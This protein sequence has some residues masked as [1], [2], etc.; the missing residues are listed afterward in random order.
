MSS[1]A[2]LDDLV[3][4]INVSLDAAP[5][6]QAGFGTVLIAGR[7]G[8]FS[9]RLLF[10]T[11]LAAVAAMTGLSASSAEYYAAREAFAAGADRVAIGRM[12]ARVAQVQTVAITTAADGVWTWSIT[13]T[14]GTFTD[15]Y[16]ASGSASASTIATALR[17]SINGTA[18]EV[19]ASGSSAN[20]VCTA[21]VAGRGFTVTITPPAGGAVTSTATTA[22][23]SVGDELDAILAENGDWYGL[24]LTSRT[25]EDILQAAAWTEGNARRVFVAQTSDA[26]V[27]TSATTDIASL[28]KDAGYRRTFVLR[29][30]TDSKGLDAGALAS[31]LSVDADTSSTTL[32]FTVV[33][34]VSADALSTTQRDYALAKYASVYL[35]L[36]GQVCLF[37]GKG[38][39]GYRLDEILVMDWFRARVE[40]AH[41]QT[42]LDARARGSK[43]PHTDK[44]Y[45]Q[46]ESDV[47]SVYA[48]GVRAG[49]F[50]EDTLTLSMPTRAEVEADYPSW[51]T[52]RSYT[53]TG[54]AKLAGAAESVTLNF[55]ATYTG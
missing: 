27:I 49:H 29:F 18:T 13:D 53:Y 52:S 24:V 42:M 20:V 11:T 17:S 38:G 34:G 35:K 36:K 50:V 7:T 26:A 4:D 1:A 14:T 25:A 8:S 10:A 15:T 31:F 39:G 44:G 55:N 30:G 40:E 28:I 43:V 48:R 32:A 6:S 37:N 3:L 5:V 2:T 12:G 19:T 54:S 41:A 45:A 47:R 16:T 51:L 46:F 9:E 33:P 23:L 21:D 22:N